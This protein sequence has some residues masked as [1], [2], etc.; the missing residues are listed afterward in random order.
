[1]TS[2]SLFEGLVVLCCLHA[3]IP[4]RCD[5]QYLPGFP[6]LFFSSRYLDFLD[7]VV[8]ISCLCWLC[9]G[10]NSVTVLYPSFLSGRIITVSSY[11]SLR[12]LNLRS[13]GFFGELCLAGFYLFDGL[14]YLV[15]AFEVVT[16]FSQS[17]LGVWVFE[18]M[19]STWSPLFSVCFNCAFFPFTFVRYTL[20]QFAV[21]MAKAKSST[22]APF[23]ILYKSP[24]G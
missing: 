13:H 8:R 23:G 22:V 11:S 24:L 1:M 4:R 2:T 14:A 12:F 7:D 10:E 3:E 21:G 15:L 20:T 5:R 19:T 9:P 6:F 17:R 18:V 16:M